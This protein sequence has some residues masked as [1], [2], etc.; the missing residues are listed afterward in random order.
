MVEDRKVSTVKKVAGLCKPLTYHRELKARDLIEE[1]HSTRTTGDQ[2]IGT[3]QTYTGYEAL[4]PHREDSLQDK[5]VKRRSVSPQ[6]K[7]LKEDNVLSHN[8][9]QREPI[10]SFASVH[11]K[12]T[13]EEEDL[14]N[15]RISATSEITLLNEADSKAP[16]DILSPE[17]EP[18]SFE[19]VEEVAFLAGRKSSPPVSIQIPS[20]EK[21]EDSEE[22]KTDLSTK[23]SVTLSKAGVTFQKKPI[24]KDKDFP[25]NEALL[26]VVVETKPSS[27]K[28]LPGSQQSER[29]S[30]Q[31]GILFEPHRLHH[32]PACIDLTPVSSH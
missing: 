23:V 7:D 28:P 5:A 21:R 27:T 13:E 32:H 11:H 20:P 25:Q 30:D 9:E 12:E 26:T 22:K 29:Q 2:Q 16:G 6:L 24:P 4:V 15:L 14:G 17:L 18:K 3:E 19:E 10:E 8:R 31:K 1:D